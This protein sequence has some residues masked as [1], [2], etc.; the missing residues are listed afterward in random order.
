MQSTYSTLVLLDGGHTT[1]IDGR[2]PRE[3]A[4]ELDAD[5]ELVTLSLLDDD[6]RN[7]PIILR[8][9]V[10]GL[11]PT[12]DQPATRATAVAQVVA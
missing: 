4:A 6:G 8:D 1:R 12:G 9:R 11:V 5:A 7:D 10:V 3:V 2:T